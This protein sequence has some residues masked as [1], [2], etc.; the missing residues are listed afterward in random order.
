M[1][2]K[3]AES[4]PGKQERVPSSGEYIKP[5]LPPSPS[6]L[7]GMDRH[8]REFFQGKKPAGPH[9]AWHQTISRGFGMG[10][11]SF[12]KKA[13]CQLDIIRNIL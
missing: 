8:E 13:A 5:P 11:F 9:E 3:L 10:G 7:T 1:D 6:G 2:K 12:N 4:K